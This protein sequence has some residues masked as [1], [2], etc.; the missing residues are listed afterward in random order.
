MQASRPLASGAADAVSTVSSYGYGSILPVTRATATSDM[1]AF[2][3][4]DSGT[5]IYDQRLPTNDIQLTSWQGYP[6]SAAPLNKA[7]A[8]ASLP[9]PK[10]LFKPRSGVGYALWQADFHNRLAT[11]NL[12]NTGTAPPPSFEDAA[13]TYLYKSKVEVYHLWLAALEQYRAEN[14][15][16]YNLVMATI[17]LSGNREETD[18]DYLARHFHHGIHRDGQGLAKWVHSL[19]D[20]STVGEQDRLQTKLAD[21]KLMTPPA[22]VT[23]HILEKHCTDVLSMWKKIVGNDVAAPASFNSRLLS[24]IPQGNTSGTVLGSLRNW[25]ADKIT[26]RAHFL[27][28]P[29]MLIDALLAHARTLGMPTST[30]ASDRSQVFTVYNNNC[31][32][33]SA[34]VCSAGDKKA[35]CICYNSSKPLPAD[36]SDGERTFVFI[37]REYVKVFEPTTLKGLSKLDMQAKIKEKQEAVKQVGAKPTHSATPIISNQ[38]EFDEWF[39]SM[40]NSGPGNLK[41]VNPVIAP[42]Y[43]EGGLC[44]GQGGPFTADDIQSDGEAEESGEAYFAKVPCV[45]NCADVFTKP[46]VNMITPRSDIASPLDT[47]RAS[48]SHLR[49]PLTFGAEPDPSAARLFSAAPALDAPAV[50]APLSRAA[51]PR[52]VGLRSTLRAILRALLVKIRGSST[53]DRKQALLV[54]LLGVIVARHFSSPVA[55]LLA[56][57]WARFRAALLRFAL[58]LVRMLGVGATRVSV[59]ASVAEPQLAAAVMGA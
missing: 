20:L 53:D 55:A 24:S 23:T 25:L 14:T 58:R 57:R 4:T 44:K 10:T 33:C 16:V 26:D 45:D 18:I 11:S 35:N 3:E 7:A 19:N 29:D 37:C 31:K 51:P 38:G 48:R 17:D 47:I 12:L 27:S 6:M 40:M 9:A 34:R 36:A 1:V 49:S 52:L 46:V 41:I 13:A 5:W 50:A 54:I 15:C 43:D 59:A 39:R 42:I 32:L 2:P 22:Q 56:S 8:V 21:A 30:G 28:E